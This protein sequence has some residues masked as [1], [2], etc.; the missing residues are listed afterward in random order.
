MSPTQRTLALLR[1]EGGLVQVVE[2]WNPHSRTRHDLF[3]LFDV[4]QVNGDDVIGVQ[5]C[6]GASFSARV[7]KLGS[8]PALV[9]WLA[10][11]RRWAVIHAWRK[12]GPGGR[13]KLW[14]VRKAHYRLVDGTPVLFEYADSQLQC[15]GN[16][17]ATTPPVPPHANPLK[18]GGHESCVNQPE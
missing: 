8:S 2:R 16:A 18:P 13:R 11:P 6:A 15:A 9:Q 12:V 3:G 10:S 17:P 4:L 1:K 14:E 5:S 7:K